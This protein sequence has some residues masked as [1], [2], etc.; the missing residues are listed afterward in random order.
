MELPEMFPVGLH[1]FFCLGGANIG[2]GDVGGRSSVVSI[3]LIAINLNTSSQHLWF[4]WPLLG[5]GIG[6]SFHALGVIVFSGEK[7]MHEAR[8][9]AGKKMKG[10]ANDNSHRSGSL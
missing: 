4:K 2:E 10:A 7:R 8:L 6:L 5:W 1:R 9:P 3:L